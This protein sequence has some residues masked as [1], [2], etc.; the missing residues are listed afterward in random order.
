[1]DEK[2]ISQCEIR[3]RNGQFINYQADALTEVIVK[4]YGDPRKV[5]II[6]S[7]KRLGLAITIYGL[8]LLVSSILYMHL[9][10]A[11]SFPERALT[12]TMCTVV[13]FAVL[14]CENQFIRGWKGWDG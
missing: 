1:M 9:H 12:T 3:L 8:P 13:Y 11:A 10:P 5:R 2:A 4:D 14:I 7:L 6:D